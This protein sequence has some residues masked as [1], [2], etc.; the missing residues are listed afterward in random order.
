MFIFRYEYGAVLRSVLGE[1]RFRQLASKGHASNSSDMYPIVY[2]IDLS[3]PDAYLVGQTFPVRNKDVVYIAQH[4]STEIFRFMS[5]VTQVALV[6]TTVRRSDGRAKAVERSAERPGRVVGSHDHKV[7][8]C[9]IV[10]PCDRS[11]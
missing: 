2:R 3:Q 9:G 7:G 10:P 5:A 8:G 6:A 11:A 4:P 1:E